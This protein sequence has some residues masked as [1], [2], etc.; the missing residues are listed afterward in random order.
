MHVCLQSSNKVNLRLLEQMGIYP[1]KRI[2]ARKPKFRS[3]ALFVVA[4]ARM[5]YTT[6]NVQSDV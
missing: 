5:R 2:R 3:V 6:S 1:D 4:V